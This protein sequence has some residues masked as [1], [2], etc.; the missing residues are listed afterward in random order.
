MRAAHWGVIFLILLPI[1]PCALSSPLLAQGLDPPLSEVMLVEVM[2]RFPFEYIGMI[3]AG[4]SSID[5]NG[6]S[7]S[8][9]EG[10]WTISKDVVLGQGTEAFVC[11]NVSFLA[12]IHP[13][14]ILID[15]N[16]D[17]VRKGR[18]A[19]A[20]DGDEVLLLDR[21]NAVLDQLAYG[22]TSIQ[23]ESW[24]GERCPPPPEGK[25]LRRARPLEP[26][27][28]DSAKDWV[29]VAPGR[30]QLASMEGEAIAEPFLCPGNMRPRILREL[31]FAQ[32]TIDVA[33]YE[34]TDRTVAT[35]LADASARGVQVRILIEGQPAGGLPKGEMETL[36]A[37]ARAGCE[38]RLISSWHGFK[39][40]DFLH[41]KYLVADQRRVLLTS[42]NWATSS[43]DMNRGWGACIDS[44]R[45]AMA[46]LQAFELDFDLHQVDVRAHEPDSLSAKVTL[47][48]RNY[49]NEEGILAYD[50]AV[51]NVFAPD[52]SYPAVLELLK[53]ARERVFLE[54]FYAT[55]K[56]PEGRDPLLAVVDAARRGA[57]VRLL[58][59]NSWY[60]R[61][62]GAENSDLASRLNRLA[63]TEGIDLQ[64]KLVSPYHGFTTLHNKG[65]VVDD[66]VLVSSLNWVTHSFSENREAAVVISSQ[67]VAS[68]FSQAFLRDWEDDTEAP[69]LHLPSYVEL[70]E[71]E[72]LLL[73]ASADDNSGVVRLYWDLGAD[74]IIEAEGDYY[75]ADLPPGEHIVRATAVDRYNNSCTA[76]V[77]VMV[78][79]AGRG[80]DYL[81]P[82][83]VVVALGC[84]LALLLRKRVKWR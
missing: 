62:G 68:F 2:P 51:T 15:A 33:I 13:D 78:L 76:E 28:T 11:S 19:L 42:E 83:G 61:E 6:W 41:C 60:N 74:G 69:T 7:I 21:N 73:N 54:L 4:R 65:M 27:D 22:R 17:M 1:F 20:D 58:L 80:V 67:E 3:N 55:D 49:E 45:I 8:D 12:T 43:L 18:L 56:W 66:K 26:D 5:L 77:I 30:S 57:S 44:P 32:H 23:G 37:L 72:R 14:A 52:S 64:A 36:D 31:R 35:G 24:Q 75:M 70:Q 10:T 50:A 25:A 16:E 9:G 29:V 82:T 46:Y 84:G 40:Y 53:G 79:P 81:M 39:R 38:V 34:L 47:D 63:R 71:G 48:L 59:D